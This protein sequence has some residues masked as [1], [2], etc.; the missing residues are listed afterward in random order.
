MR[1]QTTDELE[2]LLKERADQYLLYPS[3]RVW[4]SIHKQMHPN[5]TSKYA[6]LALL[7]FL[8]TATAVVI[9]KDRASF[10]TIPVGQ[11]AAKFTERDPIASVKGN[12]QNSFGDANVSQGIPVLHASLQDE[13]NRSFTEL[14]S[15]EQR[16]LDIPLPVILKVPNT[17]IGRENEISVQEKTPKE[18]KKN[19]LGT[20]IETVMEQAKKIGKKASWQVY[21]TPSMGY[22]RLKGEASG[23]NFQYSVFSLSTNAMFARNVKDAVSH[24]PGMGF[25][26]GTAMFYPLAKK[27][28]FKAGLQANYNHYEIQAFSSAPEIANYGMNNYAFGSYPISAVSVYRNNNGSS[29]AILRNEH[30]MIS[31]PIGIDYQVVGNNKINFSVAPTLQPTYVFANYSYLLSTDLKNYAKEPTLNRRWNMNASIETNLNIEKAGFKWSI[32]PQFRYQMLSSFKNKYPIK[33]NLMDFGIKLGV[34]K[35]IR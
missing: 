19:A 17:P 13:D 27:L 14:A 2:E 9:N 7:L 22:R 18:E 10:S 26:I 11:V 6:L 31:M 5:R 24:K 1:Q 12:F 8:A 3:D 29:P 33:E 23:S 28:N 15:A 21:A 20:A 34:I 35:T 32:A 30:Y 16:N 25:E 4:D